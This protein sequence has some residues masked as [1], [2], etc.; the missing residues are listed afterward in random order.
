MAGTARRVYD[1]AKHGRAR[2][3]S[4]A[5]AEARVR[6]TV[7]GYDGNPP[8]ARGSFATAEAAEVY[9]VAYLEY[10]RGQVGLF[11]TEEAKGTQS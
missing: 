2:R 9:R 10:F 3:W 1:P 6:G 11:A 8:R 4:G 5:N 7:D